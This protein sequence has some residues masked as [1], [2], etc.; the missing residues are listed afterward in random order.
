MVIPNAQSGKSLM[1]LYWPEYWDY[2]GYVEY[3]KATGQ[4]P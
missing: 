3:C 4:K 1:D 2:D